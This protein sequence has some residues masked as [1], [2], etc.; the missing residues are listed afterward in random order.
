[1]SIQIPNET[2]VKYVDFAELKPTATEADIRREAEYAKQMN[3]ASFCTYAQYMAAVCEV[4]EGSDVVPTAVIGYPT[5]NHPAFVKTAEATFALSQ[6]ARALE[7][8][9]NLAAFYDGSHGYVKKEI[10][11]VAQV[12]HE[13]KATLKVCL[14][15]YYLGTKNL[16]AAAML[17]RDAGADFIQTSTQVVPLRQVTSLSQDLLKAQTL[18]YI[19]DGT[20]PIKASGGITS[21][22]EAEQFIT[23]GCL[24]VGLDS[25]YK[26][27]M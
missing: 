13:A 20:I 2:F 5:G 27:E 25:A 26:V 10:E 24:R 16:V 9:I 19:V 8:V 7:M 18:L 6:G 12:A 3:Y 14:E 1:M 4:L 11:T 15:T 22:A 21:R 17:I 23:M